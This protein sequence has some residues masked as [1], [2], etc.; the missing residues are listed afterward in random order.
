MV[1]RGG[2]DQPGGIRNCATIDFHVGPRGTRR[3]VAVD[4][5]RVAAVECG[6]PRHMRGAAV[7]IDVIPARPEQQP[8]IRHA[9]MPFVG[10]VKTQT[11]DVAAVGGHVEQRVRWAD[12]AAAQIAAATLADEGDPPVGQPAGIEVIPGA[13]SQFTQFG[14]IDVDA[15]NVVAASFGPMALARI[16]VMSV[17]HVARVLDVGEQDL[18]AVV[19]QIG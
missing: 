7:A 15:E 17:K 4:G 9:R 1:R 8:F 5:A 11:V 10:L 18:P 3:E 16:H 14:P 13:V 12:A 2:G 6:D 19:G